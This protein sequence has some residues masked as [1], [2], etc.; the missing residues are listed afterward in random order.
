MAERNP[1]NNPPI[2]SGPSQNVTLPQ[3]YSDRASQQGGTISNTPVAAPD[4][5]EDPDEAESDIIPNDELF[6]AIYPLLTPSPPASP[7]A[8]PAV[9]GSVM[10]APTTAPVNHFGS[11]IFQPTNQQGGMAPNEPLEDW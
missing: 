7:A 1:N 11:L 2:S 6:R 5:V 9:T 3:S 8:V 10:P 4:P